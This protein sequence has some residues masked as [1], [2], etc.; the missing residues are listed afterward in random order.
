MFVQVIHGRVSDA[1]EVHA[2]M[3]RWAAELA[4]GADG[5]QGSTAGVTADGRFI[6]FASFASAEHARR[7]SDRPE[8]DQWWAETSKLFDGE[9][10][11]HDSDDA[12]MEEIGEPRDAGFVQVMKGRGSDPQRARDLMSASPDE[13]RNFRP[14]VLGSVTA[15]YDDGG[16]A[17]AIYFTNEAEARENEAKEPPPELKAQMDELNSL[18]A[19]PPEFFDLTDPWIYSPR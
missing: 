12:Y 17:T 13:W 18:A 3:D 11:F 7:N 14:D 10:T 9:V 19:G 16:F 6:A 4:P 8:Q 5:W 1:D 2:A 15:Q